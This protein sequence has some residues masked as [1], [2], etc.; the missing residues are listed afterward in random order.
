M[1]HGKL[2]I[3]LWSAVAFA[4][5]VW[6]EPA[7]RDLPETIYDMWRVKAEPAAGQIVTMNPPNLKWPHAGEKNAR[8]IVLNFLRMRGSKRA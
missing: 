8:R 7:D 4:G 5:A 3:V 1:G 2:L 6:A